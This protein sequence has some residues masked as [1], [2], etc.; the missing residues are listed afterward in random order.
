VLSAQFGG[1][2]TP[3]FSLEA[4]PSLLLAVCTTLRGTVPPQTPLGESNQFSAAALIAVL[5][6]MPGDFPL[7]PHYVVDGTNEGGFAVWHFGAI[8]LA[9]LISVEVPFVGLPGPGDGQHF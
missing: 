3:C 6:K 4:L 5:G 9:T 1:K 7:D 2:L 8:Q